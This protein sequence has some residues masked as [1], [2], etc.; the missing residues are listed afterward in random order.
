M[1][2]HKHF[3]ANGNMVTNLTTEDVKTFLLDMVEVLDMQIMKGFK[4]N[5]SVGYE[6]GENGGV[7]GVCLITTSHMVLHTWDETMDFQLDIY[8][9]KDYLPNDVIQ[10]CKQFGLTIRSQKFFDRK[11]NLI[12]IKE[13]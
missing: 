10:L 8:S 2:E 9:C 1:I 6:G 4:S 13:N 12:E 11:Y 3:I 5:P 7:S